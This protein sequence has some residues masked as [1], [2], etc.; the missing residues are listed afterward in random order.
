MR[1]TGLRLHPLHSSPRQ[2]R[3]LRL[4]ELESRLTPDATFSVDP[5]IQFQTLQGWGTSLAWWANVVGGFPDAARNDFVQKVF[6]PVN[7]LGLNAIRYN[8]GGGENPA[9][10]FL[11]FRKAVPG[12]EPSPGVWDWTADANQRWVLQA[13]LAYGVDQLEVGSYSPPWWMTNSGSVTGTPDGSD[14]LSPAY[15]NDFANYL[16]EVVQHF[17]DE[18]GV[19]F[20]TL[21]PFNEPN[22]TWWRFGGSQEGCHFARSTQNAVLPLVGEALASRGLS[23]TV[24][25]ADESTLDETFTSISSY[26][27]STRAWLSQINTHTYGG[28]AR[29][30]LNNLANSS[31]RNLEMSEYGDDDA[32]GLT[33]SH[34]IVND[35]K[36]LRPTTWD[37]WQAVD[38][39]D[40]AGGWGMLKSPLHNETDT[41]YTVNEKYWVMA[42]YSRFIRPGYQFLA[43]DDAN[44][45]AAYDASSGTL[46]IVTTNSGTTD[47][48]ITYDLSGFS[49]T[50]DSVTPYRT[51]DTESL[52]QLPAVGVSAGSFTAPA[53]ARSVTTYVLTGVTFT[54]TRRFDPTAYYELI[55]GN[56]GLAVDVSGGSTT[57]GAHAVQWSNHGTVHEQWSIV[58]VG[59]GYYAV[60][61]RNS[62]LVLNVNGASIQPGAS[63]IQWFDGPST[64]QRWSLAPVGD[65]S[66]KLVNRNSGLVLDVDGGSTQEGA[67]LVQEP[68]TGSPSQHWRFVQV[69]FPQ[70]QFPDGWSDSDLGVPGLAGSGNFD[71]SAGTWT[72]SGS[73][74]GIGNNSDQFNLVSQTLTGDGSLTA[75]VAALTNSNPGAQAGIM[76]RDSADPAAPFAALLVTPAG[77]LSFLWRT[78]PG[79]FP[80]QV[81]V[82]DLS[83]PI[84]VQLSR[85]GDDFTASWSLDGVTWTQIGATQTVAMA[86]SALAGL[87][88]ASLDN[89]A[90][91]TATFTDVTLISSGGGYAPGG[92]PPHGP[93]NQNREEKPATD[94]HGSNTD[95]EKQSAGPTPAPGLLT[96]IRVSSVFIRGWLLSWPDGL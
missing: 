33:M 54:G 46:V 72:V 50:G 45:L 79:G 61:D 6:D 34:E 9:Y 69:T 55:N 25:A 74:S 52:V 93:A 28:S 10:H 83:A 91:N 60:V 39:P 51:S 63:I 3:L 70:G 92:F 65:G 23:T 27:S 44:S 82:P 24:S 11:G 20:Q 31:G 95:E 94:E 22:A 14:N 38:A 71:D 40:G 96:S 64:N 41:Q 15:Y 26:D 68:D 32:T 35:M 58:G 17:H 16:A 49:S 67:N 2:R 1:L 7:G 80:D 5:A 42:N 59:G 78:T 62:G 19:T 53:R 21:S 85:A 4:E 66:W 48:N 56:S 76:V 89:S 43:I 90:L 47:T 30:Q 81:N 37:Y 13:A 8:I 87:A 77:G 36:T 29:T 12:Y 18:W 88:V 86:P 84:F 73:G 75:R 57:G